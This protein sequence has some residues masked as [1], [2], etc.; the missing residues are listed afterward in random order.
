M[1]HPNLAKLLN[2][3]SVAIVGPND[4]GNTGARA[5]KNIIDV[6]FKGAIYPVNPNYETIEARKC[7]PS[8]AALPE[9][10]DSVIISV[11]VAGALKVVREAEAI[12]APSIVLFCDG[13]ID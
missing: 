9:V 1:P 5:L 13:F 8:L 7:Y 10:P 3:R 11:P 6:G 12:G 2:P 4:K